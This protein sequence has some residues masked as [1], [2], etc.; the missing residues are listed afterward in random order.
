[1]DNLFFFLTI[2]NILLN[3][4]IPPGADLET[5]L[6]WVQFTWSQLVLSGI[7]SRG[8]GKWDRKWREANACF[9][10]KQIVSWDHW[11]AVPPGASV[12]LCET[13]LSEVPLEGWIKK[14]E[15]TN[16]SFSWTVGCSLALLTWAVGGWPR[17]CIHI[18]IHVVLTQ[19]S[20]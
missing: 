11:D 19:W 9:F 6:E 10:H 18:Q 15:P 17:P 20:P 2:L 8:V 4:W 12:G 1:M 7:T 3:S 16:S 13:L 14:C 5:G